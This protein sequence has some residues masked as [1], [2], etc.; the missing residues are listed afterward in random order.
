MKQTLEIKENLGGG[1]ISDWDL[2]GNL[3]TELLIKDELSEMLC[4][5]MLVL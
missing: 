1:G 4:V 5:I 3:N 2:S